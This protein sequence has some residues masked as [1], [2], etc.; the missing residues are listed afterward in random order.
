MI[1]IDNPQSYLETR[2]LVSRFFG[3]IH[4]D[5]LHMHLWFVCNILWK[6]VKVLFCCNLSYVTLGRNF[7]QKTTLLIFYFE[8]NVIYWAVLH[9]ARLVILRS[10]LS[11]NEK[12]PM[13]EGWGLKSRPTNR[14]LLDLSCLLIDQKITVLQ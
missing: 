12:S 13:S 1:N 5:C 3:F 2:D 8:M 10:N 11:A 9:S 4:S 6:V 7:S 14:K